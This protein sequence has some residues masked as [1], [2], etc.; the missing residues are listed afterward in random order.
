MAEYFDVL[1][2]IIT[3]EKISDE[4]ISKHFA[5]W[6]AQVWLSGNPMACYAAN[7][8]NSARGNGKVPKEAEYRFLRN[9]IKLPKNTWIAFDKSEKDWAIIIKAIAYYFKTSNG[10]AKDYI[11]IL[12]GEKVIQIIEKMI[13]IGNNTSKFT[14]VE[15]KKDDNLAKS[16]AKIK[17]DLLEIKGNK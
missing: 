8:F 10:V 9:S 17:K 1:K 5:G 13:T 3:K 6:P 12:G 14:E 4:D 16:L 11:N 2:S 15:N 7:A